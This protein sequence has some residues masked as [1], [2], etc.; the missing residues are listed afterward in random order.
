MASLTDENLMT[1][2]KPGPAE[3][4]RAAAVVGLLAHNAEMYGVSTVYMRGK[5]LVPLD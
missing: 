5:D 3:L 1:F 4:V 2:V